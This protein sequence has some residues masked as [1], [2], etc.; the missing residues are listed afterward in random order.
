MADKDFVVKNGIFVNTAFFA[1]GSQI[2][3]STINTTSNGV[4]V[5]STSIT[6][7]NASVNATINSTSYS[8]SAASLGGQAPSYY[9][10]ASNITTG[11]LPIS[12]I[13]SNIVNTSAD[14]TLNGKITFANAVYIANTL[15]ANNSAGTDGYV[16]TANASGQ[17]YWRSVTIGGVGTVTSVATSNGIGGGTIT[18]SGTLY[19]IGNNGIVANSDGIWAKGSNGISVSTSGINVTNGDATLSVNSTGVFVNTVFNGITV[20]NTSS[21]ARGVILLGT[22][23]SNKQLNYDGTSYNLPGA[24]LEVGGKVNASSLTVASKFIAN[25]TQ[26]YLDMPFYATGNGGGPGSSGTGTAG[27]LLTSNGATGSPYWSTISVTGGGF[28]DSAASYT[29]TNTHTFQ[30]TVTFTSD[31][32]PIFV[33]NTTTNSTYT[34]TSW[35]MVGASS[36][37]TVNSSSI[38]VGNSVANVSITS[39]GISQSTNASSLSYTISSNVASIGGNGPIISLNRNSQ[40]A[41]LAGFHGGVYWTTQNNSVSFN[42]QI[43]AFIVGSGATASQDLYYRSA[44]NHR[45]YSN[46]SGTPTEVLTITNTFNVGIGNTAPTN[47]LS[48]NGTVFVNTSIAIGANV[49][50]NVT[51]I[52]VGNSTSYGRVQ[53]TFISVVDSGNAT[54]TLIDGGVGGLET[55]NVAIN[56]YAY[57]FADSTTIVSNTT[58]TV[59]GITLSPTVI[60]AN[61][62]SSSFYLG[63][64]GTTSGGTKANTTII[65]TGN[66]TVNTTAN[67]TLIRVANSTANTRISP[68]YIYVGNST[69]NTS[70]SAGDYQSFFNT[71]TQQGYTNL[72]PVDGGADIGIS[73]QTA[74]E[75]QG[76][77]NVT[78]NSDNS[79]AN[80]GIPTLFLTKGRYGLTP[81]TVTGDQLGKISFR[82]TNY[83]GSSWFEGAKIATIQEAD[84]GSE[85]NGIPARL[86]FYTAN[87]TDIYERMRIVSNGN[88][89]IGITA[90]AARLHV[91]N[92]IRIESSNPTLAWSES[93]QGTNNKIWDVLAQDKY[94]YF[95]LVNDGYDSATTWLQVGRSGM[96][97]GNVSF[98]SSANV[99]FGTTIGGDFSK[100]TVWGGK[101]GLASATAAFVTGDASL[102]AK[103]DLALYSTFV[104]GTD[105]GPRRSADIISGYDGGSWGTEYLSFNVG[106]NGGANDTK[107]VTSE[108]MRITSVGNMGIGT[109][110]P[111]DRLVVGGYG[112]NVVEMGMVGAGAWTTGTAT[113]CLNVSDI[114]G[115]NGDQYDLYI[116]GI[117]YGGSPA[118]NG[119]VAV[120]LKSIILQAATTNL[121]GHLISGGGIHLRYNQLNAGYG[122]DTD[123]DELAINY[124][125]YNAGTTRFR[126]L[127]IYDGKNNVI[128]LFTGNGGELRSNAIN[129]YRQ[130]Y[131]NYGSFWRNDGTN[132]WLM[133]TNSGNQNGNYNDFRPFRVNYGTGAVYID[134]TGA[135]TTISG[136]TTISGN[137][138]LGSSSVAV[139]LQANGSYGTA[140]Q[141]LTS[142]GTATYWS[143]FNNYTISTGLTNTSGTITVNTAYIATIAANNASYLGGT[144][145]ASYQLNSTLSAN[146]ATL[147]A[148]SSTYASSSVSNTFTVG[149][150]SYF[151]A[152]GNVGIGT[153]SPGSYKLNVAKAAGASDEGE[154]RGSDGTY[155]WTLNSRQSGGAFNSLVQ[156]G[157]AAYIYSNGTVDGGSF[158]IG[159]WSTLNK[160][161]RID[162]TGNV[163][164]GRYNP[165]EKLHVEGNILAT[166]SVTAYSDAKLK[167]DVTTIENALDKV[168]NMRGVM[169]TRID[170]GTRGTGVIAQEIKEVLPEVVLEGETLS[171]AYGNIVGVLIEAIKELKAEIE[172]L[173]GK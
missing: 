128:A 55:G 34:S 56:A 131:G 120:N 99:S 90:P 13:P 133:L 163:G 31:T 157:D 139:G 3:L 114:N 103:A 108:K 100:F 16:L 169:Y 161:I 171:V 26:L 49:T 127:S 158:V 130:V 2:S 101:S 37:V 15:Y 152:N 172:I 173:K 69:I 126:N 11:T 65:A 53:K 165:T 141:L 38:F 5:N 51:A 57:Y 74:Y 30:N 145:A 146:V 164:I 52:N 115:N 23:N 19:A 116:R 68:G 59:Y 39:T 98:L 70:I 104:G 14:F 60:S 72:A 28:V 140:G 118:G 138:T 153:S 77:L 106:Y 93:D 43:F 64:Y 86:S 134:G 105:Y 154:V 18:S 17:P 143:T 125:G 66:S 119:G 21:T 32:K 45:F 36:N 50:A 107:A 46:N 136:A 151:I 4:F 110:I 96:S 155:W 89:G 29:W 6:I 137:L 156:A 121:G 166:A 67:S 20:I 109:T 33:G 58:G 75:Y 95:R 117:G 81:N 112:T 147:A 170:S 82:N 85:V 159:Q 87:N 79:T 150:G 97:V 27:Q 149:T 92:D 148:N 88:T 42:S 142:N 24:G 71:S 144:A 129:S 35:N 63:N 160:G 41:P 25:S 124:A 94:Q 132:L 135:G 168:S 162:S 91:N 113:A 84:S 7:G 10:N 9:T 54:R 1:N 12:R 61:S 73:V 48:I 83:N 78:I 123:N 8:G 22:G 80:T 102:G 44:A 40:T 47:T 76:F 111:R 167:T 62:P 122:N